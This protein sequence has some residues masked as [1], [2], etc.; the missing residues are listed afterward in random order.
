MI[1]TY[2][3][4]SESKL[5]KLLEVKLALY[6]WEWRNITL[7]TLNGSY[8]I[9]G[10]QNKLFILFR[11]FAIIGASDGPLRHTRITE[12]VSSVTGKPYTVM[13]QTIYW[14]TFNSL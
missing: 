7:E 5:T 6:Y 10:D 9:S 8:M 3:R 1:I 4:Y 12:K 11:A 13:A 14:M 2:Y